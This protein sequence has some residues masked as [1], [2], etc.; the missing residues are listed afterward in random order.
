MQI[1][2]AD[3]AAARSSTGEQMIPEG[4]KLLPSRAAQRCFGACHGSPLA[5]QLLIRADNPD[6]HDDGWPVL[7]ATHPLASDPPKPGQRYWPVVAT[8]SDNPEYG[9]GVRWSHGYDHDAACGDLCAYI[10]G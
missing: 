6:V 7:P 4:G 3:R 8:P 5:G 1:S 9:F 2:G 10:T